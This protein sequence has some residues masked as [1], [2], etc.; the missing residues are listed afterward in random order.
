[1]PTK[2]TSILLTRPL[3]DSLTLLSMMRSDGY[4]CLI[5]PM[6]I[7]KPLEDAKNQLDAVDASKVQA[8]VAT[9]RHG[10]TTVPARRSFKNTKLFVVGEQTAAAAIAQGWHEPTFIAPSSR[11]LMPELRK[12]DPAKG[13]I[14]YVRG[15]IVTTDLS[16]A[17]SKFTWHNIVSY[18]SI[19]NPHL[20]DTIVDALIA[21]QV[22]SVLVFSR[23]TAHMFEQALKSSGLSHIPPMDAFCLSDEIAEDLQLPCW[24]N[25]FVSEDASQNALL[26]MLKDI[27]SPPG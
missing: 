22:H 6:L 11:E 13:D 23:R 2:P 7:I 5:A 26:A 24:K 9:S 15:E 27:H 4:H 1:M 25:K 14:V 12:L 10:F 16:H 19:A 21:G 8:M 18:Q 3:H 20:S 17:I